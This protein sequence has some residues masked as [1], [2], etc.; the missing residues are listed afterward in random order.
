MR[1][2]FKCTVVIVATAVTV[3]STSCDTDLWVLF[4]RVAQQVEYGDA[5]NRLV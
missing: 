1:T 2:N 5:C 4:E 3:C